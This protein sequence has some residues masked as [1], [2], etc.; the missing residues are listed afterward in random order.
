MKALLYRRNVVRDGQS[1]IASVLQRELDGIAR[2][3]KSFL[4][5]FAL[6][7]DLRERGHGDRIAAGL[8]LRREDDGVVA[9]DGRHL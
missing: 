1:L 7:G 9:Y 2:H 3:R 8:R 5:R 4:A 6:S